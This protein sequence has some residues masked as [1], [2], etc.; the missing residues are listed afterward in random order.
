MNQQARPGNG[1]RYALA[2]ASPTR[3]DTLR[4]TQLDAPAGSGATSQLYRFADDP[5]DRDVQ[6]LPAEDALLPTLPHAP[7]LPVESI[8]DIT[9]AN[10]L[11]LQAEMT[12]GKGTELAYPRQ[13]DAY[14]NYLIANEGTIHAFP[15]TAT[16]VALYLE[17]ATKRCKVSFHVVLLVPVS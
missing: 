10:R 7:L 2:V 1:S 6:A 3:H 14:V 5:D 13:V 12:Q 4:P 17:Y 11:A 16:K 15:I 9:H 8:E